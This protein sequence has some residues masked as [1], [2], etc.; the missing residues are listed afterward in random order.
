MISR[1]TTV[2]GVRKNEKVGKLDSDF[3]GRLLDRVAQL[4]DKTVSVQTGSRPGLFERLKKGFRKSGLLTH[5][6]QAADDDLL[7]RHSTVVVGETLLGVVQV[8][9]YQRCVHSR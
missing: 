9:S 1:A 7:S 3:F 2:A 5:R 4:S 6:P 8:T